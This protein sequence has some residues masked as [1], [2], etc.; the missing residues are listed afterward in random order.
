MS[1][2]KK[3]FKQAPVR[4]TLRDVHVKIDG[5][6]GQ[7]FLRSYAVLTSSSTD[8]DDVVAYYGVVKVV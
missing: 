6:A 4:V 1:V 7:S 5:C 8:N 2:D 3:S